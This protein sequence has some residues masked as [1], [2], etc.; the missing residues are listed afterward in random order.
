MSTPHKTAAPR[1]GL[2][3]RHELPFVVVFTALV[4]ASWASLW[5]LD[6]SPYSGLLAH[7]GVSTPGDG[8]AALWVFAGA[9]LLMITAMML[10]TTL[11]LAVLFSRLVR[12]RLD[13]V[14]LTA[15]L[16]A[17]YTGTWL[18]FG[19]VAYSGDHVLH[20][21][22]ERA[23]WLDDRHWLIASGL[24]VAAGL[25]Q[26]SPVKDRCLTACRQPLSLITRHWTGGG[27]RPQA[28]RIGVLHGV[29]CVGCWPLML[30][31]FA[32]GA[33]DLGLMLMVAAVMAIEKNVSWGRRITAPVGA[34]LLLAG[35]SAALLRMPLS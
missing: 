30:L 1:D 24:L 21:L 2:I 35:V 12:R 3:G 11:P 16:T 19:V 4:A 18:A 26:F 15:L 8:A 27:H 10:P 14:P 6:R 34:A 32:T 29:T 13:R 33:V 20:L 31:M 23:P 5:W 22:V 9:W 28:L 7:D 25:Y 17:G